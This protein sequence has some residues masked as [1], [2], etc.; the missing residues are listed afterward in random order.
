MENT[1][2]FT[3]ATFTPRTL[4]LFTTAFDGGQKT[5]IA[6]VHVFSDDNG[7]E[8]SV[9]NIHPEVEYQT[10]EG[11]GGAFTDSAGYVFS[12][13]P[14]KERKR[15]L[16]AYF[17]ENGAGY[18][19]GR[20]HL[21]SCDFSVGHYEAIEPN[22][23]KLAT[24]SLGRAVKYIGPLLD[25]AQ[26]EYG[27]QIPLMASLWS[28]PAFMKSNGARNGGGKLLKKR[29]PLFAEYICRY[30]E[31]LKKIGFHIV[32]LTAQN[33]PK[34]VQTWDSCVYTA[35]EERDFLVNYLRP[36]LDKNGHGDVKL[37]FWDH[38]K[39]R[40][41]ERAAKVADSQTSGVFEGVAF[42]W[43]SGDHFEAVDLVRDR[44]PHLKLVQSEASVEFLKFD[45]NDI[46]AAAKYAHE[47][48]GNIN[49]GMHAFYDWNVVLDQDGGPNHVKNFCDA[50]FLF[51]VDTSELEE[52]PVYSYISH[53]SK[54]IKPG[55]LRVAFSRYTT[56]LG[57][58]ALKNPDGAVVSVILNRNADE[59]N[60][61]LRIGGKTVEIHT[62]G[63]SVSTAVI[64]S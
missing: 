15:L 64:D 36:A 59:K 24:F 48:I 22:D 27:K 63:M 5:E 14:K 32:R 4:H 29:Y 21:D 42:H 44:F 17:G 40:L 39:E 34:A 54:H 47:L 51:N 18:T 43:Y 7:I 33:E 60:V 19:A 31:E 2:T 23:E 8:N 6:S 1:A 25:A 50:P 49:A 55:A 12:L 13:M 41:Y 20:I 37:L 28:P 26:D 9:V 52:R 11:F 16:K 57:V 56:D 62:P 61:V 53:F 35:E 30:L 58:T 45:R 10:F 3:P 46:G 38:N